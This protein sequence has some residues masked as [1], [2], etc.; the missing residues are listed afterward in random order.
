MV[1][2]E[3]MFRIC[4]GVILFMFIS[5][6]VD[7][8][9]DLSQAPEENLIKLSGI[10]SFNWQDAYVTISTDQPVNLLSADYAP[11]KY[12]KHMAL[13]YTIDDVPVTAYS[14]AFAIIN[15]HFVD[16]IQN[17][18]VGFNHTTGVMPE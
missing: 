6:C 8:N 17:F 7:R 3:K 13:S 18:H 16:D 4:L 5:S 9:N 12:D 15:K 11:L 10:S 1:S 2:I 14:R